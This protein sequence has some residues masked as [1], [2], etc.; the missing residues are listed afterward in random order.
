MNK[1]EK[2]L[3]SAPAEAHARYLSMNGLYWLWHA[4][5]HFL[6]NFIAN[7]IFDEIQQHVYIDCPLKRIVSDGGL[8]RRIF[9]KQNKGM[10]PD[11]TVWGKKSLNGDFP[12]EAVVEIKTRNT[13]EEIYKDFDRVAKLVD[14]KSGPNRGYVIIYADDAKRKETYID[15]YNSQKIPVKF[16]KVYEHHGDDVDAND[17][18]WYYCVLKTQK[19]E[20]ASS[21]KK[22]V[23]GD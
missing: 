20:I 22:R 1:L 9:G 15:R 17:Y 12:L 8:D 18:R 10:R 13:M 21:T 14:K 2:I 19:I 23:S 5:E 4:P 16:E 11:I 6:T 7:R 3:C